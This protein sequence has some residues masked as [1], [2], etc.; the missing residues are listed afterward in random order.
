MDVASGVLEELAA[1]EGA[2]RGHH[3][4]VLGGADGVLLGA[5][6]LGRPRLAVP[7]LDTAMA[8]RR[9]GAVDHAGPQIGMRG[10]SVAER[11]P[12][13]MQ[14]H[15]GVLHD[16]LGGRSIS[17]PPLDKTKKLAMVRNQYVDCGFGHGAR[18]A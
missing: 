5:G 10:R 17:N 4:E 15:E 2:Q 3:P 16:L 14:P 8:Q 1:G 18:G 13:V 11:G 12:A 6:R 9:A 7:L